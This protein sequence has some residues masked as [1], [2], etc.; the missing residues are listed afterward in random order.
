MKVM[1]LDEDSSNWEELPEKTEQLQEVEDDNHSNE[2]EVP[3]QK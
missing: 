1:E 2:K 3:K